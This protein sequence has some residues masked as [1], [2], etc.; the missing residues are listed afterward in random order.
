MT[1]IAVFRRLAGTLFL[2]AAAPSCGGNLVGYDATSDPVLES[3]ITDTPAEE[4]PPGTRPVDL[5][6]LIDN[7]P[8][9]AEEQGR[10][11]QVLPS[12]VNALLAPASGAA[13]K[14]FHIGVVTSDL[15]DGYPDR[16]CSETGDDGILQNDTAS[17]RSECQAAW[18]LLF[19]YSVRD[20]PDRAKIDDIV[21]GISCTA[22]QG[23]EGC[24]FEHQLE[25]VLT[26]LTVKATPPELNAGFLREGA[27][28]AIVI[29]TSENDC[30]AR[31]NT[32]FNPDEPDLGQINMR[33]FNH[34]DKLQPV[35]RYGMGLRA[36]K[37]D[38]DDVLVAVITGVPVGAGL[39]EGAGDT[40]AG[41]L[42]DSSMLERVSADGKN[43]LPSCVSQEIPPMTQGYPAR[44]FVE[45]AGK[46]GAQ[47]YVSSICAPQYDA[48]V[49]WLVGAVKARLV[50]GI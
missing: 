43:L 17:P 33:C 24:G 42:D 28:L 48:V 23:Q 15:G 41:C 26:A 27:V 49:Q 22:F 38:P 1:K 47:A 6:L 7:S 9:M 2:L 37:D 35:D 8:E 25:A 44:R 34:R 36:L 20:A 30:S 21:E 10:F 18:P 4:A 31:D 46:L 11:I 12:L 32:I 29:L 40:I 14:D 5:L 45:L 16:P 3:E 19:A 50:T 39:C 13:V